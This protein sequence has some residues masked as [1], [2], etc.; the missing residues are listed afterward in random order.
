MNTARLA[1][2]T[3]EELENLGRVSRHVVVERKTDAR[4]ARSALK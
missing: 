1:Y 3:R 4:K 2:L